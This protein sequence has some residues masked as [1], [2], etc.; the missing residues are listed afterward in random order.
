MRLNPKVISVKPVDRVFSITWL[1]TRRCNYDCMYC[2]TEWHDTSSKHLTLDQMKSYWLD[3]Y[4]KSNHL[5]LQYKISFTGGEVTSNKHF[6]EF[7]RWLRENFDDRLSALI[8][9]TN[10]SATEKF[11]WKMY[12]FVDNIAFSIHSEFF[13]ES[14]FFSMVIELRHKL[15]KSDRIHVNIMDEFWNQSRI[16]MYKKILEENDINYSIN[17]IDY[18]RKIRDNPLTNHKLNMYADQSH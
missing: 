15:K 12:Q 3:I 10:G 13:N 1:M 7:V 5:D 17:T 2:P 14:D 18:S 6:G 9:S 16:E 8:V 11:Y 4:N